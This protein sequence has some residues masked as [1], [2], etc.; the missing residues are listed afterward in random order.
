MLQHRFLKTAATDID[1]LIQAWRGR[2]VEEPEDSTALL[3]ESRHASGACNRSGAQ[4]RSQRSASAVS[5]AAPSA[6]G[7]SQ[8]ASLAIPHRM[9][10]S[11]LLSISPATN[12]VASPSRVSS[13]HSE[14]SADAAVPLDYPDL[15]SLTMPISIRR[16]YGSAVSLHA[17][18]RVQTLSAAA[19]QAWQEPT[20]GG[21]MRPA[22][23]QQPVAAS[24]ETRDEARAIQ[25]ARPQ[26]GM[27]SALLGDHAEHPT[28]IR[29]VLHAAESYNP[30]LGGAGPA[31]LRDDAFG[32]VQEGDGRADKQG[33][34]LPSPRQ[35]VAPAATDGAAPIMMAQL[36]LGGAE[37]RHM[38]R[39]QEVPTLASQESVGPFVVG[40]APAQF[41]AALEGTPDSHPIAQQSTAGSSPG[42]MSPVTVRS[43]PGAPHAVH[44]T[45]AT[46]ADPDWSGDGSVTQSGAGSPGTSPDGRSAAPPRLIAP[47]AALNGS[48]M[49]TAHGCY[50]A[51]PTP[52]ERAESALEASPSHGC[53][54][55][56][57]AGSR[58][59]DGGGYLDVPPPCRTNGTDGH[60]RS[61][62]L[63]DVASQGIGC[64]RGGPSPSPP[65]ERP[66]RDA[67]AAPAALLR[68]SVTMPRDGRLTPQLSAEQRTSMDSRRILQSLL[69][70]RGRE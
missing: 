39:V 6:G 65:P 41:Q 4:E 25:F 46:A 11:S 59:S 40:S 7:G 13:F 28:T 45:F 60:T 58:V 42:S 24:S 5:A 62:S 37:R 21:L 63:P 33:A 50:L 49:P 44:T 30:S 48:G 61:S 31:D 26:Q 54:L 55:D 57:A 47:V 19:D 2:K 22:S 68:H 10:P 52:A 67:A 16:A 34:V 43:L 3:N 27:L 17:Q 18:C 8:T 69:A 23:L 29:T 66:P 53:Y 36:S 1:E 20:G 9:P 12:T 56:T 64:A 38:D 15:P 32:A 35:G 14:S 51:S 70:D